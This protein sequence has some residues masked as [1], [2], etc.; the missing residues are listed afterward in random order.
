MAI[1]NTI[2]L[3]IIEIIKTILKGIIYI[4]DNIVK[5]GNHFEKYANQDK[6]NKMLAKVDELNKQRKK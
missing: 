1:L 3:I 2:F 4:N 5:L 6:L